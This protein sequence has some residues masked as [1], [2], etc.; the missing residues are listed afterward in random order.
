MAWK[1]QEK[2]AC[3]V[4]R[5]H[6]FTITELLVTMGIMVIL[7]ILS[8][9]GMKIWSAASN[10]AEATMKMRQLFSASAQFAMENRGFLPYTSWPSN[11]NYPDPLG[12]DKTTYWYLQIHP[13]IYGNTMKSTGGLNDKV[14]GLFRLPGFR[15]NKKYGKKPID[16]RWDAID[17]IPVYKW[18]ASTSEPWSFLNLNRLREPAK[19]PY[20]L[21]GYNDGD[22]GVDNE[23]RFQR[24]CYNPQ[25]PS[26]PPPADRLPL[27][28]AWAFNGR[29]G[30]TYCDGHVELVPY[31]PNA[32]MYKRIFNN[33]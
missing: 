11:P 32:N 15:G 18:R 24:Y 2:G 25:F 8:F 20:L 6:G 27:G 33:N 23:E 22:A 5:N 17:F 9:S 29:L 14:D 13:Y 3:N 30:V 10:A 21:S 12:G 28:T 4:R 1:P 31:D 26:S 7:S 19:V 16:G